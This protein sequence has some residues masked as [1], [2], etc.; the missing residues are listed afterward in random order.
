M[1]KIFLVII[2]LIPIFWF[3]GDKAYWLYQDYEDKVQVEQEK[4]EL[5]AEL[6]LVEKEFYDSIYDEM[7]KEIRECGLSDLKTTYKFSKYEYSTDVDKY[8]VI[9]VNDYFSDNIKNYDTVDEKVEVIEKCFTAVKEYDDKIFEFSNNGDSKIIVI[10]LKSL[11]HFDITD[12]DGNMYK[13]SV[14]GGLPVYYINDELVSGKEVN[15]PKDYVCKKTVRKN[16][17]GCY[18]AKPHYVCTTVEGNDGKLYK[19]CKCTMYY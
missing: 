5:Q 8:Y 9:P 4:R 19:S 15:T 13:R 18:P 6:E 16:Y 2:L 3:L 11:A 7:I 12:S 1:K 14:S 10:K 17:S